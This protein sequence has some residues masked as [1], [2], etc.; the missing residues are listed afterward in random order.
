[1]LRDVGRDHRAADTAGLEG[2]GLL[3]DR[4]DDAA[5]VVVEHWAVDGAGN[6]VERELGRRAGVDDRVEGVAV[7]DP[8]GLAMTHGGNLIPRLST[9]P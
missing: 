3:V 6:V 9:L 4:A 1:M 8:H 2:T 7:A 5:L